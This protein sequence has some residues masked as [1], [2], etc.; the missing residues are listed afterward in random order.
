[1]TPLSEQGWL[2]ANILGLSDIQDV[3]CWNGFLAILK[4]SHVR[5]T[6]CEDKLVWNL[7]KTGNYSPK[8][9]YVHLIQDRFGGDLSWWWKVLWK[10]KCPLKSKFFCWFLFSDKALTWD[11]LVRRGFEGHGRCYLC[12]LDDESNFHLGVDCPFTKSVW[13]DIEDKLNFRNLWYGESMTDC[14]KN[15]CLNMEV[16]H[17]RSLPVIV[18]WF[19][20]KARNQSYFED[21]S[22][23]PYRVDLSVW[24]C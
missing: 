15:W 3:L 9:G 22:L 17:I 12:K 16:K 4:A 11:V 24:V 20:W 18:L 8:D 10:V 6:N 23:I 7:S 2:S 5:L 19:L 21:Q 1:M 13:L 14:L